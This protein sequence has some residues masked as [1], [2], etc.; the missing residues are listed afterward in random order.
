MVPA[1]TV[2]PLFPPPQVI[3]VIELVLGAVLAGPIPLPVMFSAAV[4]DAV[5]LMVISPAGLVM[6]R[7]DTCS[8]QLRVPLSVLDVPESGGEKIGV[9]VLGPSV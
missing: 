8:R 2:A 3:R 4:G 9:V 1:A 7:C 5:T 6:S